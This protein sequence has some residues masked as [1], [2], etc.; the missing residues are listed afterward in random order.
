MQEDP[1]FAEAY[2]L[3]EVSPLIEKGTNDPPPGFSLPEDDKDGSAR[4]IDGNGTS[5]NLR[6]PVVDMGAYEFGIV[7][8]VEKVGSGKVTSSPDAPRR[9]ECGS[10]CKE[11]FHRNATITLTASPGPGFV[12]LK[13]EGDCTSCSSTTCQIILN[14]DQTCRAIFIQVS[15]GGKSSGGCNTGVQTV[16]AFIWLAVLLIFR[17][18]LH[19]Y[20]LWILKFFR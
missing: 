1:S 20:R 8:N 19:R 13:W 12:F 11:K 3:S 7:L 17:R 9:I 6:R 16:P 2:R 4:I 10:K 18:F 15:G 14:S 5:P